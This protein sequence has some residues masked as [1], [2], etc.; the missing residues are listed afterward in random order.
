VKLGIVTISFNQARFLAES[1]ESV[2]SQKTTGCEYV[3]VDPGS[4]DG[5]QEIIQRYAGAI[6]AVML[7]PDR[8]PG[9]GLNK[10]FA[11]TTADV[12]G[13][14]NSDDRFAAG[15]VE[16][17]CSFFERRP[18]VDVLCGAIR[19]IDD[20]GRVAWRRRTA[21]QF[22]LRRYEAGICTVGQQATFFRRSAFQAAGGF[23]VE[24]QTCWDG[25][26]LVDMALA[27]ASFAT[28]RRVLGEFRVYPASITGSG[29]LQQRLEADRRRIAA[30]I[31]ARGVALYPPRGVAMRRLAYKLDVVRHLGYL[32]VR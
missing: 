18:E 19:M 12:L 9:D 10:G 7:Q 6:D 29:R 27:G 11:R 2:A 16:F 30:K 13:Y 32:L 17:V 26:L 8:G 24:N 15:A 4:T 23:N 1:I 21:D 22:D 20:H 3:I 14:I 31:A 28:V 25:E 5:S